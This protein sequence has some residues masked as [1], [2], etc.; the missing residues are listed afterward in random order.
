MPD[1][2]A[3]RTIMVDTQVRPADVTRFPIIA[4]M[5]SV[6]RENFVPDTLKEAA[7]MGENLELGQGRVVLDPRSL[8]KMID[9]LDVQDGDLV[10]DLGCGPGYSAAVLSRLAEAVVA[11]EPEHSTAMDAEAALA[12]LGADNVIVVNAAL[13]AGSPRHGPYDAIMIEGAVETLPDAIIG[14]LAENGRI[15]CIFMEGV[16]G[17]CRIGRKIDGKVSW[18]HAFNATAPVLPGFE[19]ESEFVF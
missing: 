16:L 14:Q 11:V 19:R 9:A 6:P 2:A 12:E 18:R 17:V 7:Y 5:L 15:A 1:Y 4:A 13:D 8:A 10:L 3:R